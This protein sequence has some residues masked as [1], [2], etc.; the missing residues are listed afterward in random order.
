[1]ALYTNQIHSLASLSPVGPGNTVPGSQ[2]YSVLGSNPFKFNAV[3]GDLFDPFNGGD[4]KKYEIYEISQDLLVL[5]TTWQ[6]IREKR[7]SLPPGE[8]GIFPEK[9]ID[10]I[11]FRNVTTDDITKANTVRDYYSKKIMMWKLKG[12][13]LTKFRRDMNDF[14]HSDGKKF[15]EDIMPLV[16]CLPDFYDQDV[17][18]DILSMNH[19]T[20]VKKKQTRT[21]KLRLVQSFTKKVRGTKRKQYWFTDVNDNLVT[22][23]FQLDNP[24]LSLFD[25]ATK[26]DIDIEGNFRVTSRDDKEFISASRFT[27][28]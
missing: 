11:L 16:Y 27:F 6:R 19:N 10:N 18:F 21:K 4:V 20:K 15:R 28:I 8:V 7:N 14:I 3:D 12:Q 2:T 23:Q 22:I 13:E 1:M 5:S 25:L 17:A 26:N 9:I 24:L